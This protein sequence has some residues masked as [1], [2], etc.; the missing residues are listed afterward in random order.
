MPIEGMA[1]G[2]IGTAERQID[3]EACSVLSARE[4]WE[5]SSLVR[6]KE[7]RTEAQAWVKGGVKSL[8]ASQVSSAKRR[9]AS[10]PKGW[11]V[12]S[13]LEADRAA[14]V[15]VACPKKGRQAQ[16]VKSPVPYGTCLIG[17]G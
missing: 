3:G 4:V 5:A 17:L 12:N 13:P 16:R 15:S 11:W 7:I 8:P 14:V 9:S 10:Q 1:R 2:G 6:A